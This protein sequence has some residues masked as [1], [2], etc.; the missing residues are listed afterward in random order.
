MQVCVYI[1]IQYIYIEHAW[2][3]CYSDNKPTTVFSFWKVD[4]SICWH[5]V[6]CFKRSFTCLGTIRIGRMVAMPRCFC[7]P[8]N[9]PRRRRLRS[10]KGGCGAL[11]WQTLPA[12]NKNLFDWGWRLY[13]FRGKYFWEIRFVLELTL[14]RKKMGE[15]TYSRYYRR[16]QLM[17][18]VRIILWKHCS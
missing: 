10:R 5:H 14:T 1:Y 4:L 3:V 15:K 13:F 2:I 8:W 9:S 11:H 12:G 7:C 17:N 16:M 6:C 18:L